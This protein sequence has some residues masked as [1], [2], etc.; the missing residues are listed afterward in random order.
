MT[1]TPKQLSYRK[2]N[3]LG[4]QAWV[5]TANMTVTSLNCLADIFRVQS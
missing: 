4:A 3:R 5:I 2:R 1:F